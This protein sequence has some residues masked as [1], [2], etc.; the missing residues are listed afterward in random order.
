MGGG[1][2]PSSMEENLRAKGVWDKRLRLPLRNAEDPPAA[3]LVAKS[4][5]RL[6]NADTGRKAR[7]DN[8]IKKGQTDNN[9]LVVLCFADTRDNVDYNGTG[10]FAIL[11]VA[12]MMVG[13]LID[14][15]RHKRVL[16]NSWTLSI[17]SSALQ[18]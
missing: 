5:W 6:N 17:H 13:S 12:V 4:I 16:K 15:E 11:S 3:V 2:I 14:G 10:I 9:R 8:M 18:L 1:G 7:V